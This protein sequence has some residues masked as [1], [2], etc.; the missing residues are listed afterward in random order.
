MIEMKSTF[1]GIWKD[2]AVEQPGQDCFDSDGFILVK[3]KDSDSV[4]SWGF[5]P[6]GDNSDYQWLDRRVPRSLTAEQAFDLISVLYPGVMA[7][8][9]LDGEGRYTRI[10]PDVDPIDIEWNGLT[11]YSRPGNGEWVEV[12]KENWMT[13]LHEP[14]ACGVARECNACLV[15]LSPRGELLVLDRD[16][17]LAFESVVRVQVSEK[18]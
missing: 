17:R 6:D 15:G 3:R 12:T 18:K 13:Y 4:L 5:V 9:K 7:I 11:I 16:G 14:C 2:F 8:S 1:G 10:H